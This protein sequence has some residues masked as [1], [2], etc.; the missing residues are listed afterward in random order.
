MEHE[1][2]SNE[3]S[4]IFVLRFFDLQDVKIFFSFLHS[5]F[6]SNFVSTKIYHETATQNNNQTTKVP[7]LFKAFQSQQSEAH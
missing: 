5:A 3:L 7:N 2:S 6:V 4:K 1:D